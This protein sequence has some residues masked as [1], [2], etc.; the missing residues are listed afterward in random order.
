MH[1]ETGAQWPVSRQ[2][3]RT[4]PAAPSARIEKI[5]KK[6][7]DGGNGKNLMFLPKKIRAGSRLLR[8]VTRRSFAGIPESCAYDSA[9][10]RIRKIV[11]TWN[12]SAYI[13]SSDT[14]FLYDGWNLVAEFSASTSASTSSFNLLRSYVWGLD[15]SGSMQGAGGVGG[16]LQVSVLLPSPFTLLPSYDGNGN[17]LAL[18]DS[19]TGTRVAEYEYGPFGEPLKV[20]GSAAALNPFRF[21]TKYTDSETGLLY[22]GFRYYSPSLRRWP[23]K[24]PFNEP[25][26]KIGRKDKRALSHNQDLNLYLFAENSPSSKVDPFGLS[27]I[28]LQIKVRTGRLPKMVGVDVTG[29]WVAGTGPVV[30]AQAAFFADSCEI[31]FF[32]VAPA[33]ADTSEDP[34]RPLWKKS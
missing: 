5:H 21:S 12:G 16:L 26:A 34:E 19:A 9:G 1:P 6:L 25:G 20:T 23:S 31:G 24:D 18:V 4:I 30:A 27:A 28:D 13:V 3:P 10:R 11:K 22:Y 32:G 8:E 14:R 2:Q 33:A 7:S 15:L 29:S 17:I